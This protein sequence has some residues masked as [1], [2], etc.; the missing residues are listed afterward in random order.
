[1]ANLVV[2][3]KGYHKPTR[4]S[5]EEVK[6][7]WQEFLEQAKT[8]PQRWKLTERSPEGSPLTSLLSA[9]G[10]TMDRYDPDPTGTMGVAN[11]IAMTSSVRK[12]IWKAV[13][14]SL[15]EGRSVFFGYHATLS[16]YRIR[17]KGI[18]VPLQL[19]ESHKGTGFYFGA[20]PFL[21]VAQKGTHPY[22][23]PRTFL[24]PQTAG[25]KV[26]RAV[27]APET[28]F[29]VAEPRLQQ[30]Y[31]VSY[32]REGA[33]VNPEAFRTLW[34][35]VVR[36]MGEMMKLTDVD[37]KSAFPSGRAVE[38]IVKDPKII[39]HMSLGEEIL[40][41]F[42]FQQNPRKELN[43]IAREASSIGSSSWNESL[44]KL[45]ELARRMQGR[46]LEAG[47][48]KRNL[49]VEQ[50]RYPYDLPPEFVTAAEKYKKFLRQSKEAFS[51][52]EPV[53]ETLF[54]KSPEE[55]FQFLKGIESYADTY[56]VEAAKKKFPKSAA[57][58]ELSDF[59][60]DLAKIA[61]E[62]W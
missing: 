42:L 62:G 37:I 52:G 26:F 9:V 4:P 17:E 18:Q 22:R 34:D 43:K 38:Y 31:E 57:D 56:G 55:Y 41:E 5:A 40:P 21:S 54:K 10:S 32:A 16:P 1:M 53:A 8:I 11:P 3:L 39:K 61:R 2:D 13:E 7:K 48:I 33:H 35:D 28:V 15:K 24:N 50:L 60:S 59:W 19:R 49:G 47:Q 36:R 12:S 25:G 51:S 14:E 23:V 58:P 6:S 20:H 44:D 45:K 46:L 29:E 27:L 30:A